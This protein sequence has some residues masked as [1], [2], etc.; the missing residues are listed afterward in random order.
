MKEALL[1]KVESIDPFGKSFDTST[2]KNKPCALDGSIRDAVTVLQNAKYL[3]S[4]SSKVLTILSHTLKISNALSEKVIK[5]DIIKEI[6]Y[7]D[8]QY[9][10]NRPENSKCAIDFYYSGHGQ[11]GCL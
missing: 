10:S 2:H 4:K 6:K 7:F 5:N 11:P 9:F 3:D 1:K 8:L